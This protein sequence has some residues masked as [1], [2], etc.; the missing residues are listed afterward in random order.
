MYSI[1]KMQARQR[2][3]ILV[4]TREWFAGRWITFWQKPS[5]Y[6]RTFASLWFGLIGTNFVTDWF[7]RGGRESPNF[8]VTALYS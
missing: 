2:I 1:R 5:V 7:I 6:G 4:R 3:C 8:E